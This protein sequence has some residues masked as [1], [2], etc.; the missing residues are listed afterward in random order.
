M[1]VV[2]QIVPTRG[3]EIWD[4]LDPNNMRQVLE[5][6][7]EVVKAKKLRLAKQS[8]NFHLKQFDRPEPAYE[9]HYTSSGPDH[10]PLSVCHVSAIARYSCSAARFLSKDK[11]E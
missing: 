7:K 9:L 4:S 8:P 3:R 6:V 2:Q 10:I 11:D 5:A 1:P